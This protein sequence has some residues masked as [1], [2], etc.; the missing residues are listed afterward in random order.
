MKI[1][2]VILPVRV[3]GLLLSE[4][5]LTWTCFFISCLLF[6]Q[7][8]SWSYF[9]EERG[10]ARIFLA[11]FSVSAGLFINNLYAKLQVESRVALILKL[12]SVLGIALIVQGLLAY[13]PSGLTLPRAVM[14]AG[15]LLSFAVLY[16]WRMVYSRFALSN[17]GQQEIVF[18][19]CDAIVEEIAERVNAR[20]EQGYRIAGYVAGQTGEPK[21]RA[22]AALGPYLGSLNDVEHV[23]HRLNKC[24]LIVANAARGFQLPLP[25]LLRLAQ[26][27]MPVEEAATAYETICGR[28]CSSQLRPYQIIF[29]NELPAKPGSVALQSIYTNLMALAAIILTAPILFVAA[30]A[31]KLTSRGPLLDRDMRVGLHGIPFSLHRFR[32]HLINRSA[33]TQEELITPVGRLLSALRIVH[34]PR[35]FNLLRGEITLVGPKPERPEFVAELKRFFAFYEQRHSIK[36]GM[37]GWSQINTQAEAA[38]ADSLRQL[39]YDLYYTKHISLALDAYIL[40]HGV[41]S[42]LP[43]ARQS[44]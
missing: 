19:G 7:G 34:L 11:A 32:C 3:S 27:G 39:E 37:T 20:P 35:L 26:S 17:A 21:T 8:D 30:C 14:I 33:E 13:L 40:L 44:P 9:A 41:R 22:A 38:Q 5:L 24:H 2:S 18:V 36:P 4:F 43:F 10:W 16:S 6:V 15:A 25:A 23:A 1:F 12:S 28:V 42:I 29:F 31:V